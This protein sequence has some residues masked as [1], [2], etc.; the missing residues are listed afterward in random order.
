MWIER[1]QVVRNKSNQAPHL[2]SQYFESRV[3]SATDAPGTGEKVSLK[4]LKRLSNTLP[5][6]N[7]KIGCDL[8]V[9]LVEWGHDVETEFY[10][11]N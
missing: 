2:N 7:N 5:N 8:K 9:C 1:L 4:K 11:G 10:V 6:I 3:G